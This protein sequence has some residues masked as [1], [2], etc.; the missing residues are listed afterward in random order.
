MV[1]RSN[2]DTLSNKLISLSRAGKTT[3]MVATDA[4]A[5]PFCFAAAMWLR[6]GDTQLM[7]EFGYLP[8]LYVPIV[9]L[10]VFAISGLYRAVI[11]FIDRHLLTRTIVSLG[12]VVVISYLLTFF[13]GARDLRLPRN[14]LMIY[15][16]IAFAY[17]L[18]SRLSVRSFLR[19]NVGGTGHAKTSVAI[20]GEIGRAHV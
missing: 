13:F 15:W 9:T 16:L 12:L 2:M 10:V 17:I 1:F 5:L 20:Y 3:L 11:R 18:I 6:L 19:R 8:Y 7:L 4:L 14:A